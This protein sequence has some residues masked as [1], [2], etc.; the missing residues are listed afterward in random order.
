M[1]LISIYSGDGKPSPLYAVFFYLKN[2]WQYITYVYILHFNLIRSIVD[3]VIYYNCYKGKEMTIRLPVYHDGVVVSQIGPSDGNID[4][5]SFELR[6]KYI[7]NTPVPVT[8]VARSGFKITIPTTLSLTKSSFI[9]RNE[10]HIRPN[11]RNEFQKFISTINDTST[12]ELKQIKAAYVNQVESNFH[13]GV[14]IYIDYIMPYV[15]LREVG[16]TLY[17]YLLDIV[18]S[19][20]KNENVASHPY[21]HTGTLTELEGST[22]ES[23]PYKARNN[24]IVI[25]DDQELYGVRYYNFLNEIRMV[26]PTIIDGMKNGIYILTATESS[27][28]D[29]NGP[30]TIYNE[31]GDETDRK[32][33]LFKVKEGAINYLED[34][35]AA[36]KLKL[37]DIEV[38]TLERKSKEDTVKHEYTLEL[39]ERKSREDALKHEHILKELEIKQK[40]I[41]DELDVSRIL[42]NQKIETERTK[43]H[44]EQRSYDR[45]DE[46]EILKAL[47]TII[48]GL[49]GIFMA[50][51]S[52][53]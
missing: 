11:L 49:A 8:V 51:K 5:S 27:A 10:Y 16:G 14:R 12:N 46:S 40:K 36:L 50:Y 13:N 21:S 33:G 34:N 47:P 18:V 24:V 19:I 52:F 3:V 15:K 6:I 1:G 4:I 32:L 23:N 17:N 20:E 45:K 2:L 43:D 31:L 28:L 35:S 53:G 41:L 25:V 9:V 30:S 26:T 44:Y 7:N 39:L 29:I 42:L 48:V 38:E 37:A 22:L